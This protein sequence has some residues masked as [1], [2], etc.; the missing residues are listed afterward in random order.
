MDRV[1]HQ[2]GVEP[3]GRVGRVSRRAGDE[4]RPELL[5]QRSQF[6]QVAPGDAVI[7]VLAVDDE[8][9]QSVQRREL[10]AA[11]V[12]EAVAVHQPHREVGVGSE[13]HRCSLRGGTAVL[14]RSATRAGS[15]TV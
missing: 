5:A 7:K 11:L 3:V 15:C 9:A 1:L 6:L 2:Q 8:G 4:E 14:P 12:P 13:I 10:V